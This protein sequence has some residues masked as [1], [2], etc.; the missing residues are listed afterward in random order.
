MIKET[1]QQRVIRRVFDAT[2]RPLTP[3]DVLEEAHKYIPN[4]GIATVYRSLKN[5]F[6]AGWLS[7]VEMGKEPTRYER[8]N[9][10]HH[11]HFQCNEC[12][13]VFDLPGC[14]SNLK[15]LVPENFT[16]QTHDLTLFGTCAG[17]AS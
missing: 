12:K 2:E 16:L 10:D 4:M 5:L 15:E 8:S 3:N 14:I 1:R 6:E 9:L 11:H 7:K 13:K 17:C